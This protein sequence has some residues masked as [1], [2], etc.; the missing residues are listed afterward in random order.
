VTGIWRKA[1]SG[2]ALCVYGCSYCVHNAAAYSQLRVPIYEAVSSSF[3]CDV[4]VSVRACLPE[5]HA[6]APKSA[7]V[8]LKNLNSFR[9]ISQAVNYEAQRHVSAV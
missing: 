2:T 6:A 3:R 7:R 4:N 9:H 8:E 1:H 5:A